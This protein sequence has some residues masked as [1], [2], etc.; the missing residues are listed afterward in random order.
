[1]NRAIANVVRFTG[2]PIQEVAPMAST[3]PARYLGT[4]PR[5]TVIADWDE[6]AGELLIRRIV[7]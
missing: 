4:T 3:I 6:N 1:M 2:L 5:G 7:E